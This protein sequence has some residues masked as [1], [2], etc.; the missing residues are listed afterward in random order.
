MGYRPCVL[1]SVLGEL[2]QVHWD[3][4]HLWQLVEACQ[5]EQVLD[6]DAHP[7]C[8][9]LDPGHHSFELLG[10]VCGAEAEQLG[11]ATDGRERGA[12]LVRGIG[13][14]AAQAFLALASSC[15]CL[16]D[17][18]EHLVQRRS[19]P[20][21]LCSLV[22]RTDAAREISVRDLGSAGADGAASP[23]FVRRLGEA[24]AP[25]VRELAS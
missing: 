20:P 21:D 15:E 18:G 10:F 3:E 23:G 14:E 16:L 11:V 12:Q 25:T 6:E 22:V 17:L 4:S 7:G 5:Q 1:D 13:Q 24:A 9:G 19:E 2:A 8:L